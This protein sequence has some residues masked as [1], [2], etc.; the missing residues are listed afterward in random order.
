MHTR[1]VSLNFIGRFPSPEYLVG[2]KD[3][4]VSEH[5]HRI[6][7]KSK[8]ALG[9]LCPGDRYFLDGDPDLFGEQEQLDVEDPAL[10]LESDPMHIYRSAINNEELRTGRPDP[11]PLDVPRE[12]AIRDPETRR[13]FIDHLRDLREICDQF[14]LVLEEMAHKMPYGLRF[15]SN[16]MFQALC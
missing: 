8:L 12:V 5:Q 13:L 3:K 9:N 15:L 16:Q 2:A 1:S 11:R 7:Q 6:P 4:E 10:D 14:F